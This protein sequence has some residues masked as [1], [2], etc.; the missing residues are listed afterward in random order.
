VA[1]IS[2]ASMATTGAFVSVGKSST[3]LLDNI[4]QAGFSLWIGKKTKKP[5]LSHK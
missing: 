2:F 5:K 3:P 1:T 4:S